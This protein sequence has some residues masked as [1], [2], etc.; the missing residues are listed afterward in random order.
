MAVSLATIAAAG[1]LAGRWAAP[2]WSPATA[3]ADGSFDSQLF[4]LLNQDRAANGL[5]PLQL[6]TRLASL[7]ESGGYGGCGYGIA[8]RAEDMIQRNYFS[9]TILN[10]GGQNV[11]NVMRAYGVPTGSAGENIGWVSGTTNP[12][13]AAQYI[14]NQFMASPDHRANIL[15]P[16][17]TIV[18]VGSWW[19]APGQTWSGGGSAES[20]ALMA[21]EEF[22]VGA[23][24][25]ASAP[26]PPPVRSSAPPPPR[27][28]A[29]PAPA[30]AA[31]SAPAPAPG[32]D[33]APPA[34]AP[35]A[36]PPPPASS[37]PLDCAL[38][39]PHSVAAASAPAGIGPGRVSGTRTVRIDGSLAGAIG[40]LL[41]AL[42]A[43]CG[44]LLLIRRRLR[45]AHVAPRPAVR[46]SFSVPSGELTLVG[47]PVRTRELMRRA[48]HP[49][50]AG[51]SRTALDR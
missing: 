35:A 6:D 1:G 40:R 38:Q 3:F 13:T 48:G 39:P 27:V 49:A 16:N 14:N 10:C 32:A 2:P 24:V 5:G 30:H 7:S 21:T 36:A 41:V 34:A 11:F 28:Q 20:N 4:S 9:H 42:V 44:V 46:G 43:A 26:A 23:A 29:A 50:R 22:A 37:C 33:Q 31:A 12:G 15:N 17:Y 19:T 25:G 8:G 18:G 51:R 45:V 47:R